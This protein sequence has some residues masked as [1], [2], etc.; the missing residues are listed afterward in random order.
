MGAGGTGS[1]LA[2]FPRLLASAGLLFAGFA[3][4]GWRYRMRR[5]TRRSSSGGAGLERV[6]KSVSS[7]A[8]FMGPLTAD[9]PPGA[10]PGPWS[11]SLS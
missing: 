3:E 9:G 4:R 11:G 6:G 7:I 10:S 5:N 1:F 2:F 8:M